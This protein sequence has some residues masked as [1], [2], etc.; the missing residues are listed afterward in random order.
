M[1]EAECIDE[2]VWNDPLLNTLY[3]TPIQVSKTKKNI[4]KL[5]FY[6]VGLEVKKKPHKCLFFVTV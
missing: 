4:L 6:G 3:S 5:N 2:V 1:W